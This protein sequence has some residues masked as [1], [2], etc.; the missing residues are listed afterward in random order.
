[1]NATNVNFVRPVVVHLVTG[2]KQVLSK[3]LTEL[4][5]VLSC[6]SPLL[7]E[8]ALPAPWRWYVD[9]ELPFESAIFTVVLE[10]TNPVISDMYYSSK[11]RNQMVF[12][13][14]LNLTERSDLTLDCFNSIQLSANFPKHISTGRGCNVDLPVHLYTSLMSLPYIHSSNNRIQRYLNCAVAG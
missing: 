1:M 2:S 10:S 6:G 5:G 9:F 14:I 12:I 8:T 13:D 4:N 3:E 11:Q 7:L